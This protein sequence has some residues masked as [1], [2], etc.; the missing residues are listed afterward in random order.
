MKVNKMEK[1]NK[2]ATIVANA[3]KAH[4]IKD[5]LTDGA[6][7]DAIY[8]IM[9]FDDIDSDEKVWCVNELLQQVKELS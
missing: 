4:T 8:D 2:L 9:S 5:E 3:I 1:V 6:V 7:L